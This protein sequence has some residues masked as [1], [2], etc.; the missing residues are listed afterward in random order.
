MVFAV[1]N[2][3]KFGCNF[4]FKLSVAAICKLVVFGP[5]HPLADNRNSFLLSTC[6]TIANLNT[7]NI[8]DPT[9]IC[10]KVHICTQE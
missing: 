8:K 6:S 3:E 1:A 5:D 4:L 9:I 7:E 10:S 2:I